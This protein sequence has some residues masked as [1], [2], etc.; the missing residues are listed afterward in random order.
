MVGV[1]ADDKLR[2]KFVCAPEA[3]VPKVSY[4]IKKC[5]NNDGKMTRNGKSARNISDQ[6]CF[7]TAV[8]SPARRCVL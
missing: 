7:A 1:G 3:N 5:E 4:P 8:L 6:V 2:N